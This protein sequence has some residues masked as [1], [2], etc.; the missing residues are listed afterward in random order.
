MED[1]LLDTIV[2]PPILCL[3][4]EIRLKI[5]RHLLLCEM[6]A[7]MQLHYDKGTTRLPNCLYP[8][9]LSTCH[10]IYGEAM[11]VL[12]REN[13]FLAHRVVD[14]N[15]NAGLITRAVFVIGS[16]MFR[17]REME[18]SGLAKFLDTH[19]N[20]KFLGLRFKWDLLEN[21]HIRD[22]LANALRTSGYSSKLS[23]LSEFKSTTSSFNAEQ[24][25][26]TVEMEVS[27]Q[28]RQDFLQKKG[29][30]K[31]VRGRSQPG[32]SVADKSEK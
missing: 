7:R 12:Y 2:H 13:V 30:L 25:L 6:W 19:P 24:L 31:Q 1:K 14:S 22:I 9:I 16:C 32:K 8:A 18:A 10:L 17:D 29:V 23:I 27:T 21:S 5:Y 28:N 26:Q 20:L 3:P 11:D 15:N 4:T